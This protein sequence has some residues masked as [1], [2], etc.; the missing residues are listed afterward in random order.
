ML[1]KN[2]DT[3]FWQHHFDLIDAQR[4]SIDA[5]LG[6]EGFPFLDGNKLL[7]LTCDFATRNQS[8]KFCTF[9]Q[10][11]AINWDIEINEFSGKRIYGEFL[12]TEE[13]EEN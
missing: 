9:F 12:D 2:S 5:V 10:D 11:L 6:K 7:I 13:F 4:A 3:F 8:Q 1:L